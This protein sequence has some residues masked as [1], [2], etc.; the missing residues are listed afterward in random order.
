[1]SLL[2]KL[3]F[4]LLIAHD[5][6]W[7]IIFGKHLRIIFLHTKFVSR[8]ELSCFTKVTI[9]TQKQG[10]GH[11]TIIKKFY[12]SIAIGRTSYAVSRDLFIAKR[13]RHNKSS[14]LWLSETQNDT[15]KRKTICFSETKNQNHFL[16][17]NFREILLVSVHTCLPHHKKLS[18][19]VIGIGGLGFLQRAALAEQAN[20]VIIY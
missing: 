6:F 10:I 20:W 19:L 13:I 14:R 7:R 9:R 16:V 15:L 12:N 8:L 4:I 2:Q 11:N 17:N 3:K 1:M 18:R 5:L